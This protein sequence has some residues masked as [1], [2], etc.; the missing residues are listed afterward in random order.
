MSKD[1][2]KDEG[3]PLTSK[4]GIARRYGVLGDGFDQDEAGRAVRLERAEK[5]ERDMRPY[6]EAELEAARGELVKR[7]KV[8]P[9]QWPDGIDNPYDRWY[10]AEDWTYDGVYIGDGPCVK[11]L[12][13]DEAGIARMEGARLKRLAKARNV[14]AGV[15]AKLGVKPVVIDLEP[16]AVT[17]LPPQTKEAVTELPIA[18]R[19]SPAAVTKIRPGPKPS[20][21]ALSAAERARRARAKR[22]E[23]K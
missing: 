18:S 7:F 8:K 6:E 21:K 12:V 22:M 9:A 13:R 15:E 14:L 19:S 20:G 2:G 5:Y 1:K 4:P 17:E 3:V 11:A 10:C 16:E 23:K